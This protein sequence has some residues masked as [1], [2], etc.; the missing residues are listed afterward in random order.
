MEL[1]E[2]QETNPLR[3]EYLRLVE[4][5][6]YYL[7]G[8]TGAALLF[9]TNS[10]DAD[11]ENPAFL[12]LFV[13]IVVLGLSGFF[14]FL[15]LEATRKLVNWNAWAITGSQFDPAGFEASGGYRGWNKQIITP[16]TTRIVR[17]DKLQM[18]LFLL[19]LLLFPVWKIAACTDCKSQLYKLF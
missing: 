17:L 6:R 7:L 18:W 5:R 2:P 12:L 1:Q 13:V 10:I 4:K 3:N 14:G 8:A 16:L 19:A 15:A 9:S 11:A